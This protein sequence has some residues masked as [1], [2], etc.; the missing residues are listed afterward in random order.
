MAI[1]LSTDDGIVT[2]TMTLPGRVNMVGADFGAAFPPALDQ[3]LATEGLRGIILASGHKDFCVGAD[4]DMLFAERDPKVIAAAVQQLNAVYRKLET[5]GVPVVAALTGSALGGGYELALACH[6]RI[7]LDSPRLQFGLPEVML[8]VIPGAGGTQRLPYLLGIQ[9]ALEHIGGASPVRAAKAKKLGMVDALAPNRDALMAAAR[10]WIDENPKPVQPWD[11]KKWSWPG[12]TRP[13]TPQAMQLLVGASAF[14]YKKTAG[15]FPAAEAALK[16][17]AD[18]TRLPFDR[19]IEVESRLFT[20]LAVS[21]GA[22]DMIR[23]LWYHRTAAEKRGAG[24]EHGI[25]KVTVLGAGMM[26]AGLA[27]VSAK[28]GF[29]VV[30][31]DIHADALEKAQAHLQKQAKKL[32]HLSDDQRGEL[33]AR[34]TLTLDEEP[35][36]GTDLL[37]EA[38]VENPKVKHAVTRALEPLLA[39]NGIWASNTSAIPIT[40]LAEPSKAPE[41]FIGLHFFSPV[42]KMPLLE[43]VLHDGCSEETLNRCL[44]FGRAIKKTN[45]VVNDGYGFFTSRLF[46]AYLMEGVEL[47]AEGHDPVVIEHA[48]RTAGMVMPPLKVFDEVTLTLGLHVFESRK[49][50]T[51]VEVDTPGL[52]LVRTLVEQGR[53]GKSTGEGFYDWSTRRVWPGLRELTPEPPEVTGLEHVRRR[54]MLA[55]AAE[56]GRVL[57]DGIIRDNL[58]VEVGAIMGLGFAPNT[59]GPLAWIDRQGLPALV[60]EMR[61]MSSTY[62]D[63]YAPSGVL[64]DMAERNARFWPA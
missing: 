53:G 9:A 52:R 21:D 15:A 64:V 1:S 43:V 22:K 48:A 58:D 23:T 30:L 6:H 3:A 63:R 56:V 44:A 38:V 11:Q 61:D 49:Q 17:I 20:Q 18:G 5:S 55:Q 7:A 12:G 28:A 37:I 42:E 50:V 33:L 31:K 13:N 32:R 62:G 51:G 36:R 41:N 45:I 19:G 60:Q 27:F 14:L 26:G 40:L 59:G 39:E 10:A 34:I 57:D 2:L 25:R 8:G 4:I 16:A 46:A 47:L 35:I 29:E 54:L 24:L